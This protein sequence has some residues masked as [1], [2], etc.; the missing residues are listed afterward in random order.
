MDHL[1]ERTD[2][3]AGVTSGIEELQRSGHIQL[4]S[5]GS[6]IGAL[7]LTLRPTMHQISIQGSK[8]WC[9][10]DVLGIFG[11]LGA[12]GVA[13]STDPCNGENIRLE[14]TDGKPHDM[15]Y[16]VFMAD[17]QS[18]SALCED[19]CSKVNFFTSAQSAGNGLKQMGW[20]ALSCL[21]PIL[22]PSLWR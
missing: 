21:L 6:I 20:L 1:V 11:A 7:G 13:E 3:T 8:L 9:A 17:V 15:E 10:F 2:D 19:W 4:D 5:D 14:F 12:S 18:H 22:C 16:T